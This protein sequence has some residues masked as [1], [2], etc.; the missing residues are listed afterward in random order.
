MRFYIKKKSDHRISFSNK[1]PS[2]G[3]K[4]KPLG[5]PSIDLKRDRRRHANFDFAP[6]I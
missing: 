4:I 3:Y 1:A 5:P 6:S 2:V